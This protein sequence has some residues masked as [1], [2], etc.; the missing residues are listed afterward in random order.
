M[1][2]RKIFCNWVILLSL[3]LTGCNHPISQQSPNT[4]V[5]SIKATKSTNN[6]PAPRKASVQRIVALTS[7][8]ADIIHQ[9]DQT[10]LVGITG[11]SLLNKDPRFESI[12]RVSQ[13]QTLPD[14]EKIIALKPDLVIG[15]EGFSEQILEQLKKMGV[16]TFATKVNSWTSLEELTKTL[17]GF[18]AVDPTPLLNRYQ[19]FLPNHTQSSISTLVLVSRQP[20][21]T[22]N[23]NSWAGDLLRQFKIKNLAADLQGNSPIRGYITLSPEKVL[24][25]N[26]EVIILI[27]PPQGGSQNAVLDSFKKESFWQN[28]QATKNNQVYVFDY[29]GLVNA[30]SIDAIE[31]A[32][33]QLKQALYR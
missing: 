1:Y 22:P 11:S 15:A 13:G 6:I 33:Q 3:L 32:C 28:L 14:L 20:I 27:S 24:A 17:A 26:P 10:K 8:S 23:K 31:K 5:N 29:Y 2:Q 25:A 4:P 19:T 16:A 12:Q 9:L 7:L 21:L 18:I 30:G